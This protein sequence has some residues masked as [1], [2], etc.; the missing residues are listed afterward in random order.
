MLGSNRR[1]QLTE[2][3]TG[4]VKSAGALMWAALLLAGA[5]LVIGLVALSRTAHA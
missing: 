5:A 2:S 4:A 3:V 1:A